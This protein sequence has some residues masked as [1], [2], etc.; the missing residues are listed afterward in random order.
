MEN[1]EPLKATMRNDS[2]MGKGF[3]RRL[4]M[5]GQIPAV[6]YGAGKPPYHVAVDPKDV[7]ERLTGQFGKNAIFKLNIEGQAQAPVVRVS[8]YQRDPV[9]RNILHVDFG[10]I[11]PEKPIKITVPLRLEGR[12][13]GVAAGGRLRQVRREL[14]IIA[15]PSDIPAELVLDVS[16]VKIGEFVKV[17]KVAP[18][19]G[20]KTVYDQDF[21]VAAVFLPRGMEEDTTEE[22][23]EA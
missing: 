10:I 11:D 3:A 4:R 20:V 16:D 8:E 12:P 1:A 19:D 23:E 2:E 5:S 7:V 14:N 13:V 9:K 22:E 21:A 18:P 6:C 17:S 15:R